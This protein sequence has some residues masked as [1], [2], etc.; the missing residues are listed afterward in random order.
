MIIKI[1]E[2]FIN[3]FRIKSNKNKLVDKKVILGEWKYFMFVL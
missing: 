2:A 1:Q 3:L